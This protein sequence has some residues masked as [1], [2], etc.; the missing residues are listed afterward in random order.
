M[1]S[2]ITE[3]G[4]T[5]AVTY[6]LKV[7]HCYDTACTAATVTTLDSAARVSDLTALTTGGDGLGLI[8]YQDR[9]SSTSTRMK[10]AHCVNRGCTSA[11]LT[12]IDNVRPD[13]GETGGY[14]QTGIATG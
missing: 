14:S 2:Y 6:D 13:N 5:S 7:A 8:S 9:S 4:P 1:I 10:V 11:T 3:Q 12:T